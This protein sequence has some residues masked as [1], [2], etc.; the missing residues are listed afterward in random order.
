[1]DVVPEG[2]RHARAHGQRLPD[3]QRVG[4]ALR[5]VHA[6][7]DEAAAQQ[8]VDQCVEAH[9]VERLGEVGHTVAPASQQARKPGVGGVQGQWGR[10]RE[11]GLQIFGGD[12]PGGRL[13]D[14]SLQRFPPPFS[15]V[16]QLEQRRRAQRL[17]VVSRYVDQER[18]RVQAVL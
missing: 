1:M 13:G 12:P 15:G 2:R 10:F 7:R 18:R 14:G 3:R 16:V 8:V 6:L 17:L 4:T 11:E 9:A 5:G